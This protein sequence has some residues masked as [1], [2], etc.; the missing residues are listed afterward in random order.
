MT[1]KT[2][3]DVLQQQFPDSP[4]L[5]IKQVAT[6]LGRN[7]P[8][9]VQGIYNAISK[10]KFPVRVIPQGV[11]SGIGCSIIDVADYI[12]TGVPY[13]WP[14]EPAPDSMKKRRGR[15]PKV[16][17][18]DVMKFWDG[19]GVELLKWKAEY[20][21]AILRGELEGQTFPENTTPPSPRE[22]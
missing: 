9:S 18:N 16:P 3:L 22:H 19:V 21:S 5:S 14:Q 8:T 12:E 2:M 17:Y 4:V 1:K 15:P 10:R 6:A 20:E 11:G 7:R 13:V